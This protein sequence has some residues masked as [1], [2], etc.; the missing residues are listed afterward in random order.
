MEEG[1][2]GDLGR[3]GLGGGIRCPRGD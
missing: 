1:R 3:L 2:K